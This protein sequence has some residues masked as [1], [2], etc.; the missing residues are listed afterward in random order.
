MKKKKKIKSVQ[1]VQLKYKETT[2]NDTQKQNEKRN[3]FRIRV[4]E[5]EQQKK[6]LAKKIYLI[7]YLVPI[8]FLLFLE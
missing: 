4:K 6:F 5:K 7:A 3:I 8:C 1:S 2:S